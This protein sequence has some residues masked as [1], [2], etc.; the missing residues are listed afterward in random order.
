MARVA[1]AAFNHAI[2]RMAREKCLPAID[3][4]LVCARAEDYANPIEPSVM[5]GEKIARAIWRTISPESQPTSTARL[6]E[7]GRQQ[8]QRRSLSDIQPARAGP[9][10]ERE[11]QPQGTSAARF[12][13][14]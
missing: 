5:G 4:R 1:V 8:N 3:L 10:S 13:T 6:Y 2:L 7:P 9:V 12:T 14:L 11:S